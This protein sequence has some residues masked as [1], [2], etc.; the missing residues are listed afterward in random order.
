VTA[1]SKHFAVGLV[2][3]IKDGAKP[4]GW[5]D[6]PFDGP[7]P[8]YRQVEEVAG[9]DPYSPLGSFLVAGWYWLPEDVVVR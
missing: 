6:E 1:K 5:G 2:V 9:T 3:D 7:A 4:V 8:K